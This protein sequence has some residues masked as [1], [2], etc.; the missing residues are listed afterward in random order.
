MMTTDQIKNLFD[1]SKAIENWSN[2]V[3]TGTQAWLKVVNTMVD[4]G[5]KN[6]KEGLLAL[7]KVAEQVIQQQR[8]AIRVTTEMTEKSVAMMHKGMEQVKAATRQP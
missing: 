5:E 8:E 3:Q 6:S 1:P 7:N 4:E 2:A